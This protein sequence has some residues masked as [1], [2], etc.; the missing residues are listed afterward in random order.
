[1]VWPNTAKMGR[2][3]WLKTNEGQTERKAQHNIRRP[4]VGECEKHSG[5]K[6]DRGDG[7]ERRVEYVNANW[8]KLII[9]K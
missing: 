2:G 4:G 9:K 3:N 7:D 6:H 5:S 1:M 8:K